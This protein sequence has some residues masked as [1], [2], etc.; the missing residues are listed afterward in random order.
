MTL[1]NTMSIYL[2]LSVNI[3]FF[4]AGS[5]YWVYT[6]QKVFFI[7][8]GILVI[9]LIFSSVYDLVLVCGLVLK[10]SAIIPFQVKFLFLYSK[11]T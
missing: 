2:G 7:K 10:F 3:Y 11:E 9:S 1:P 6:S 5:D 8:Q 4:D